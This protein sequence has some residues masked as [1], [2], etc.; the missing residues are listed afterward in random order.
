MLKKFIFVLA[1]GVAVAA[2][3]NERLEV[4]QGPNGSNDSPVRF[5]IAVNNL[6]KTDI[7]YYEVTAYEYLALPTFASFHSAS[8]AV[9]QPSIFLTS[10]RKPSYGYLVS[11]TNSPHKWEDDE[12]PGDMSNWESDASGQYWYLQRTRN[13]YN[14]DNRFLFPLGNDV[15]M[16][17]LTFGIHKALMGT[18]GLEQY[19]YLEYDDLNDSQNSA[20]L[21]A[22]RNGWSNGD[23]AKWRPVIS[24]RN[25]YT[26]K[27]R[28]INVDTRRYQ[29]DILYGSA[30]EISKGQTVTMKL[31][32][33]QA[34]L[35]FNVKIKNGS[36]IPDNTLRLAMMFIDPNASEVL[37]NGLLAGTDS[38]S[39]PRP[40]D[41]LSIFLS[42][43]NV[44]NNNNIGK[45]LTLKTIGT[46]TVDNSKNH[47]DAY[48]Y[49]GA[50]DNLN[51]YGDFTSNLGEYAYLKNLA[52][53]GHDT[54]NTRLNKFDKSRSHGYHGDVSSFKYLE[55]SDTPSSSEEVLLTGDFIQVAEQ[56]IPEQKTVN[57]W[58]Y[59]QLGDA[60]YL[61]EVNL[62]KGTWQ[63]GHA[64]IYNLTLEFTGA[65]FRVYVD[66]Y[67]YLQDSNGQLVS[68]YVYL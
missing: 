68:H 58:L 17:V 11:N 59:Y 42:S 36:S 31:Q 8:G 23:D 49:L 54:Q 34:L 25:N 63:M 4:N 33:A 51:R 56:L 55:Y 10:E 29:Y 27:A 14:A 24:D 6:T 64:Y 30:N 39:S 28:F 65:Q 53:L 16:D 18:S 48:W 32:H 57:P 61:T 45:Y 50:W 47:L 15:R 60:F 9:N 12:K 44:V 62:P 7:P 20:Y 19:K 46:F 22:Y 2:C 66:N 38:P 40:F 1:A 21:E 26:N 5:R 37:K 67:D 52:N 35:Y 43:N 3:T 41:Y 13:D